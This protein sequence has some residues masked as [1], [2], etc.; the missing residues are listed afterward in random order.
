MIKNNRIY[1]LKVG[2]EESFK[3]FF[4]EQDFFDEEEEV[5]KISSCSPLDFEQ[6]ELD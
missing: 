5:A 4:T 3:V 6:K 2:V 1:S